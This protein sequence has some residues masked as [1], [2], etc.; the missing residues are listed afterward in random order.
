MRP[1]V[2]ASARERL[3]FGGLRSRQSS[4]NR[5][6]FFA[7]F[8]PDSEVKP[9]TEVMLQHLRSVASSVVFASTATLSEAEVEKVKRH[10][11]HVFL[12]ENAGYDFAMWRH[13]LE[14]VAID[15]YDEVILTNSSVIGPVFPLAPIFER[16][17]ADP[18]D[19]WG[20]TDSLQYSWHLQSYFIV[21][22]KQVIAS[23]AFRRFWNSVLPYR[24]KVQ[25]IRS[26]EIGLSSFLV[27]GG[28]RGRAFAG[29]D[30]WAPRVFK[31][32]RITS[33]TTRYPR[34]LLDLGMPFVKVSVLRDNP[35]RMNLAPLLRTM[36][37]AGYPSTL[38]P[39][40]TR[41]WLTRK[42]ETSLKTLVRRVFRTA[43]TLA[44]PKT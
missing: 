25:V 17:T 29:V 22:K 12:L 24:S 37:T 8:D 9:F 18:C 42:L 3:E 16:M 2:L 23:P 40:D 41:H 10:A 35:L 34:K 26:Y 13:A 33:P 4:M 20:M 31:K 38:I 43:P 21:F 39:Y 5:I 6:A 15:D 30:S 36:Q 19:F 27:D 7:H 44:E 14:N 28:F 32:R 1:C 11:Q